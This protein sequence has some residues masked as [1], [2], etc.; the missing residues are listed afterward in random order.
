MAN[1]MS[2]AARVGLAFGLG[3]LAGCGSSNGVGPDPGGGSSGASQ[4]GSCLSQVDPAR[5]A[6]ADALWADEAFLAGLGARPTAS[7]SHQ[8]FLDWIGARLDRIPGLQR[9]SMDFQINRWL[10]RQSL[11]DAGSAATALA[12]VRVSGAVPYARPTPPEGI[13]APLVYVPAGTAIAGADVKGRIVLRD[14][15]T[16]S[17]P[18][19]VFAALQWWEY[20]P[21]LTLTRQIAGIYERDFLAY[22]QRMTDLRDAGAAGA[23]G[24]VL[25][26]GFPYADVKGHYAP[27]E[28][29]E[30]PV[31]AVYVGVDEA[32]QLKALAAAGGSARIR[33]AA[34]R[35]T[36]PT[37][38]LIATLPGASA[39]RIVLESHTDGTN[40]HEDNGPLLMLRMAEYFAAMPQSCRAKTLEFA[41][42]TAHFHQQIFP[43][44]RNGGAEQYAEELDRDYNAGTV[45]VVVA[46]EHLGTRGYD[47]VPRSDGPG[48]EF[49][50]NGMDEAKSLFIT[51]SPL[52]IA[53]MLTTVVSHDLRGT[54]ALR[55]ADLPG[56]HIPANQSFGGEGTPYNLHLIPTIA[57]ISAPW[58]LYNPAFGL[59]ALDRDLLYRQSLM[60]TDLIHNLMPLSR[61]LMAGSATGDRALRATL[62]AARGDAQSLVL[63]DHT[64]DAP[65]GH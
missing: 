52:L 27:Y 18:Q 11:L 10:E 58:P 4:A 7:P 16:G 14:A 12:P 62:C 59:E 64:P 48:R 63:C 22:D 2:R 23:A 21:D 13:T 5:F 34:D 32:Q 47:A 50:L 17:V 39:E 6:G 19:A 1:G 31:P 36:V 20:D 3:L 55:G 61:Y 46:L 8:Q 54:I 57:Y 33:L 40:A 45:D 44:L 29:V 42:T 65:A 49:R 37:Q 41:F 35:F 56:A 53:T 51:D 15:A 38:T 30:W 43:P 9:R 25:M 24:M 26:H 60:F 28:G